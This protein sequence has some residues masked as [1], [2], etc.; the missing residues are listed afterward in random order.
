MRY[1]SRLDGLIIKAFASGT[2]LGIYCSG[3]GQS[4]AATI[5][6]QKGPSGRSHGISDSL[7]SA[8][9]RRIR[10]TRKDAL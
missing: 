4:D 5:D 2:F 10:K 7:A 8:V 9:D 6:A 1:L 3:Y